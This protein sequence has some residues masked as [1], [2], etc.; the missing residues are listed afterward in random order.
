MLIFIFTYIYPIYYDICHD[1]IY[2]HR[3]KISLTLIRKI[4]DLT[5]V[6]LLYYIYYFIILFDDFALIKHHFKFKL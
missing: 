5:I 3:L 6:I 4:N 2:I 1:F